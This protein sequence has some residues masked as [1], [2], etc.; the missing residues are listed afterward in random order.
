M[1]CFNVLAIGR[2]RMTLLRNYK[3]IDDWFVKNLWFQIIYI[4]MLLYN[5]NKF[6]QEE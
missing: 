5:L 1:E 6:F 2:R 3:Y 4:L